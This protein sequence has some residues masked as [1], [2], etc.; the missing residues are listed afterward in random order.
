VAALGGLIAAAPLVGAQSSSPDRSPHLLLVPD[1]ARADAALAASSARTVARYEAFTLVEARGDDEAAL[2]AAGSDRR[3]DMQRVSL[4]GGDLDPLR[5]RDSLAARGAPD[6]DETL[7][8]IQFA[9]PIKDAWLA[10]LRASGVRVVQYVPQNGYL[11]HAS[12]VEVER[13]AGLVGTAPEVRAVT[14]VT[15]ADKLSEELGAGTRMVAVQ[16]LSGA[17]GTEARRA[18]AAVGP[19]V[20]GSSS[21]V[22][23]STQYLT[24]SAAERVALAADPAVVSISPYSAPRLL[25]ERSAQIVAGNLFDGAPTGGGQY[26]AWLDSQEFSL[27][28]L[29]FAIDVADSGVDNGEE[30]APA[31]ADFYVNGNTA[32]NDRVAYAHDFT[33]DPGPARDCIGH[34]SNVASIAAG[35]SSGGASRQDGAGFRHGLGAAPTVQI[36]VSKFFNCA[37]FFDLAPG[38]F[39]QLAAEAHEDGA[40]IANNS[41]GNQDYGGYS[42]DSQLFDSIVRD[43]RPTVAGHQQLVEV[44]AAGNEADGLEDQ[45]VGYPDEGWG[46]V[47]SPG[48]AKNVITVGASESRRPLGTITCGLDDGAADDAD[49][50]ASFSSRGPTDDGRLKPD[51]VAPGTRV[52]GA[53][54]QIADYNGNG[55]CQKF[56]PTGGTLYNLQS[57]TSQAT[58]AV[59]GAAAL[60]RDWYTREHGPNPPSPA[61]TKAILVN[62]ATDLAGG[63]DGRGAELGPAPNADQGWGRAHL[64]AVLDGT[65]RSY[66]DQTSV[67]GATGARFGRSYSVAD[68]T[69]PLKVTLA[70]TDAPGAVS[71]A[72]FVNDLDLVLR[73]GGRTY[74]GNVIA[75]GRS[76]TGGDADSRNN[77]E[78]VLLPAGAQGSFSVEVIGKNVA[79]DGV[80]GNAD[81]TDQD[82]ALVVSNAQQQ[83]AAVLAPEDVT[84]DDGSAGDGDDMLEPSEPFA[85]NV[86]LA[87]GGDAS[88]TGVSGSISGPGLT[89][90]QSSTSWGTIAPGAVAGSSPPMVGTLASGTAC[91]VDVEATLALGS[92]TVPV[93]LPTG[94]LGPPLTHSSSPNAPIPDEDPRGLVTTRTISTAGRVKDLDVRVNIAHQWVGD[95]V[96]ELTS[97]QGTT[98]RLAEHPGG[99]DNFGQNLTGTVFDDEA[100]VNIGA[101]S[102]PYTGRFRPQHD[103]LSRFDG[104]RLQGTWTLRVRDL[105]EDKTGTLTSWGTTTGPAICDFDGSVLADTS[106]PETSITAAPSGT[107]ASQSASFSFTSSEPDST[108]ECSLD[109]GP[110]APCSAPHS[111]AGL[112]EGPHTLRV[113][114]RDPADNVDP[115]PAEVHWAVDVTAPA[116]SLASPANGAALVDARPRISG[117]AGAAPGDAATVTVSLWRGNVATGSPAQTLVVPHGGGAW[118]LVPAALADGSWT[119]RVSQSDAAGNTGHSQPRTFS[120][121]STPPDF[122]IAPLEADRGEALKG[123][124]TVLA[125][126]GTAC[127][128]TAELLGT[129]RRPPVLGRVTKEL[130][131]NTSAVLRVKL[132]KKGRAALRRAPKYRAKLTTTIA[133]A[134]SSV[135]LTQ[136]VAFGKVEPRTV[137]RRGLS[138]AGRCSELCGIS[139]K[140]RMRSGGRTIQVAATSPPSSSTTTRLALRPSPSARRTLRRVPR[141]NLTFEAVLKAPSGPSHRGSHGITVRR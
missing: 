140:L 86:S 131:R 81:L 69:R 16:T 108:F 135:V 97:P 101:G 21:A 76:I 124:L 80:P 63:D 24:L 68:S 100:P 128:V 85:L 64:G 116:P 84:V 77:L 104:Q 38:G 113:Q 17:D 58:P 37:G 44:F 62:T 31:H 94:E 127:K 23:L 102:A 6:L 95:L 67:L 42:A 49:D 52:T 30:G 89:F 107:S 136:A 32:S 12:A 54:P 15:A 3:D 78:S 98:V 83:A 5:A 66:V 91:G 134:R 129:G 119:A 53:A 112:A 130:A 45:P 126:C 18:A 93:T 138:F 14:R 132:T 28:A 60:I 56:F 57:G 88:A 139:A 61:L 123:R 99:P 1:T 141:A 120:V 51:L 118:S 74:K 59:S 75:G 36:G 34:G 13:L 22:G 27:G 20:R 35:Y 79:G 41:W 11:V 8:V 110:L 96:V 122:A 105:F 137:A 90:S 114:A 125:G 9:G 72:A 33:G 71:T 70:W 47:A 133:R 46:S 40:R 7:A 73:Q 43:A 82:F 2:R 26:L 4:P 115:T 25:D 55:V 92:Q 111:V 29:G 106:P 50:I 65:Q 19:S 121:D 103:Q 10:R 117:S 48:T 39:A 87:N 109:G